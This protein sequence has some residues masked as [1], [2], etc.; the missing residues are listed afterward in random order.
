MLE[1]I[2]L[3]TLVFGG[4]FYFMNELMKADNRIA[5]LEHALVDAYLE[6]ELKNLGVMK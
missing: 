6:L 3:A 5:E 2:L 1:I 4:L